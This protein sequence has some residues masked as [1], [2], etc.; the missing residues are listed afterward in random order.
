MNAEG[1]KLSTAGRSGAVAGKVPLG[2]AGAE[3]CVAS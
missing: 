3:C 2:P 1:V